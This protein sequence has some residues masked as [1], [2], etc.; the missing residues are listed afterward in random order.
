[1]SAPETLD[2]TGVPCPQNAAR[3]L[4]KLAMMDSGER[5]AVVVDDGEPIDMVPGSVERE[6]HVLLEREQLSDGR[7][8]L[9]IEAD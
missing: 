4:L 6:D 2:L 9:L 5:L 3:T 1:M 7:W 8:R